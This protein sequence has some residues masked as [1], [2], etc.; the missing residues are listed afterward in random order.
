M[1][2]DALW[3]A[4]AAI[5][6]KSKREAALELAHLLVTETEAKRASV[7][8]GGKTYSVGSA[9]PYG[10]HVSVESKN[11]SFAIVGG[12]FSQQTL[13]RFSTL[14]DLL[15]RSPPRRDE[16]AEVTAALKKTGGNITHAA[17]ALGLSRLGLKKRMARL[18]LRS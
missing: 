11:G 9:R 3:S 5:S 14:V 17:A 4:L 12:T 1:D 6:S 13:A 15:F 18:G 2:D 7:T 10:P 16:R 8:G